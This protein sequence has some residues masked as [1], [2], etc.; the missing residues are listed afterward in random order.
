MLNLVGKGRDFRAQSLQTLE[1]P[2]GDNEAL[3]I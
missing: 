3:Y 1:V 2:Q